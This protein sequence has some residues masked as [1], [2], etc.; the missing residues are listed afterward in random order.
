METFSIILTQILGIVLLVDF[1][2]GFFHWLEDAY[3]DENTPLVGPLFIRPN[4]LHHHRPRHFVKLTWLQSSWDLLCFGILLLGAAWWFG[5]LSWQL[6]L[7]TALAVNSNQLHK[8]AH[9]TRKENGPVVSFLQDAHLLQT[10]QHHAE[11]HTNPKNSRYCVVTNLLNPLLDA[12]WFWTALE[13]L[14]LQVAGIRR[15][16]D[17]SVPGNGPAPVWIVDKRNRRR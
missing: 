17:T 7:F 10:P 16:D 11:H 9:C 15:R 13:W 14:V 1:L 12:M 4:I 2:S 6:A 3:G 5:F 8:W